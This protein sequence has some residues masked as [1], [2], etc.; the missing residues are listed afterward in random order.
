MPSPNHTKPKIRKTKNE[1]SKQF[2]VNAISAAHDAGCTSCV[3]TTPYGEVV[4]RFGGSHE[5]DTVS[6][7]D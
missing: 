7:F 3:I 2:M 5:Q 4:M 6:G 1:P